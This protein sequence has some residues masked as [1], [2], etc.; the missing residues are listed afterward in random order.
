M[1]APRWSAQMETGQ[2]AVDAGHRAML[3][4]LAELERV[5][6]SLLAPQ[7]ESLLAAACA[8]FDA[9]EALIASLH[10]PHAA[11]HA[12]HH[13][14]LLDTLRQAIPFA[15]SGDMGTARELLGLLPVWFNHHMMT[16]DAALTMA[17]RW[18]RAKARFGSAPDGF[19]EMMQGA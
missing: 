14:R 11:E 2:D 9:E 19:M 13:A 8:T 3:T 1:K 6:D 18:L 7:L 17:A 16:M 12:A 15:R 10:L 5:P 4:C